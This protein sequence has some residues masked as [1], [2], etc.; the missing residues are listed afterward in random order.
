MRMLGRFERLLIL[1]GLFFLSVLA[2]TEFLVW[3]FTHL[4][5]QSF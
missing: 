4:K 3:V 2:A 5:S 1:T